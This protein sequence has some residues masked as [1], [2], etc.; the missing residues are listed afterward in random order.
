MHHN[1]PVSVDASK[2]LRSAHNVNFAPDT[3]FDDDDI[4]CNKW[5]NFDLI[6]DYNS[7]EKIG[8]TLEAPS[9]SNHTESVSAFELHHDD[10]PNYIEYDR[11]LTPASTSSGS[12][13]EFEIA[14]LKDHRTMIPSAGGDSLFS[15][16]A[17]EQHAQHS[18]L[19]YVP[20]Q[21][22][23]D[24]YFYNPEHPISSAATFNGFPVPQSSVNIADFH[25]SQPKSAHPTFA[26]GSHFPQQHPNT[27]HGLSCHPSTF[28]FNVP[29]S[30]GGVPISHSGSH[31][32]F[33]PTGIVQPSALQPSR[34]L[35]SL[36]DHDT[37]PSKAHGP[38]TPSASP[39]YHSRTLQS[40]R[41]NTFTPQQQTPL[42]YRPNIG[43]GM[44]RSRAPSTNTEAE[45]NVD[46]EMDYETER[47]QN[48]QRNQ[49][50]MNQLGLGEDP[51]ASQG[52]SV[53][54]LPGMLSLF[55]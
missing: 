50:L 1:D 28:D 29:L 24:H 36:A 27:F 47:L 8:S 5:T 26:T 30:A 41:S 16:S 49:E 2:E 54:I 32:A 37:S 39:Q 40:H 15:A 34:S 53:S 21:P 20:V 45:A 6:P 52:R 31:F 7:F 11:I 17:S 3:L 38:H 48:I 51:N 25:S 43:F 23:G 12:E 35:S 19:Q 4:N 33:Q 46:E 14:E 55:G 10:L 9:A 44:P 42:A 22:Q 13:K 18:D